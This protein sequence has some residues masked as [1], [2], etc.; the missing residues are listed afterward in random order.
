VGRKT[1][2]KER[3]RDR[4]EGERK[5]EGGRKV[6]RGKEVWKVGFWN[7]AGVKNMEERFWKEI[8]RWEVVVMVET[9]VDGKGWDRVKR[10]LPKDY[11]LERQLAKKRSKKGRPIG[12]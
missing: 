6:D 5:G 9:W 2:K 10:M 11:R 4:R 12:G 1:K 7:V 3:E 8:K